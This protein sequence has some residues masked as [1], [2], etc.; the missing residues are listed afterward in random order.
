VP[1]GGVAPEGRLSLSLGDCSP[2]RHPSRDQHSHHHDEPPPRGPIV[3]NTK[4]PRPM[5]S[6]D[7]IHP[8]EIDG[9]NPSPQSTQCDTARSHLAHLL[10]ELLAEQLALSAIAS[11]PTLPER[12]ATCPSPP[13]PLGLAPDWDPSGPTP[14]KRLIR[15]LERP[16]TEPLR[17]AADP[18]TMPLDSMTHTNRKASPVD[19]GPGVPERLAGVPGPPPTLAGSGAPTCPV[20]LPPRGGHR[21][22]DGAARW[23]KSAPPLDGPYQRKRSGTCSSSVSRRAPSGSGA[24]DARSATTFS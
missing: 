23:P 16:E 10:G 7:G 22:L 21:P 11:G 6:P 19:D 3:T 12:G 14:R 17:K 1:R 18:L 15:T 8:D 13:G 24:T 5:N 20:L 9:G 2:G 4:E